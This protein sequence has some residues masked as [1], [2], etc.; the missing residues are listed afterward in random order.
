MRRFPVILR[1]INVD[2]GDRVHKGQLLATLESPELDKQ[3]ADAKA[4]YWLQ[5]VTDRRNQYL[6]KR[7]VISQQMA[8]DSHATMLQALA[9]YQQLLAMQDYEVVRAPFDGMITVRYVDPGNLVPQS[10]ASSSNYPIVAIA[11]LSPLRVYANVPQSAAPFI[12][13]RDPA[14]VSVPE[15]AGRTFSGTV[16][17][18]PDALDPTTR[19]MLVEIDLA[20]KDL[21][22]YPGM[23][24]TVHIE[25]NV[26]A[27]SL[28]VP[29]DALI[30]RKAGVFVPVVRDNRLH[31]QQVTLGHDDGLNVQVVG[32]LHE[33]DLVAMNVGQSARDGEPVQPVTSGA[34][35][36]FGK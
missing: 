16:T 23:Y 22:L 34:G 20:N 35:G 36:T 14:S 8:D 28:L 4:Y 32:P 31:L 11:S 1:Q 9:A 25:A 3:V 5:Q 13:D 27:Q 19:T 10:T 7:E 18:H 15:Y 21:S 12:R 29:D 33:G 17:R 24:A 6:V 26:T 2:K 30:F